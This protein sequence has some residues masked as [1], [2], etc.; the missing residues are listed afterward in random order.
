[1]LELSKA[2]TKALKDEMTM[3]AEQKALKNVGKQVKIV[4]EIPHNSPPS[5]PPSLSFFHNIGSKTSFGREG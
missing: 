5:L 3:T 2:Y 1:M 4:C